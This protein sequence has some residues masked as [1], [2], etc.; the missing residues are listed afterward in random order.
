MIKAWSKVGE[1]VVLAKKYGKS[2]IS[3]MF[4]N[5][6][7]GQ[8]EE[9]ALFGQ[10][11]WSVVL[12]V[13]TKGR[14]LVVRQ[15]KQGCDKIVDELPAGTADFK[16]ETAKEVALRESFQE[17]RHKIASLVELMPQWIA[18]RSS[19]TR[20]HPFLALRCSLS[21]DYVPIVDPSE[22]VEYR[23]VSFREWID[24]ILSG[25]VEEPSAIVAT[26]LALPYLGVK[27]VI[28]PELQ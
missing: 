12:M 22:E 19:W 25:Q 13:T 2:F 17:T 3:Q 6:T 8:E 1:A 11:D 14:V 26:F 27:F 18:T 21:P 9:F 5:P 7:T 15:Y 4:L 16:D 23:E 10:K 24:M 28:P 20:F